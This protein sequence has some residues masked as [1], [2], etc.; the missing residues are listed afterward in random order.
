MNEGKQCLQ[1]DVTGSRCLE[2]GYGKIMLDVYCVPTSYGECIAMAK[3]GN[4]CQLLAFMLLLGKFST[5][6]CCAEVL[7]QPS[8]SRV[9]NTLSLELCH[10]TH[11]GN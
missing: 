2:E 4:E 3:T 7:F 11:H 8:F 1:R 10:G 5:V 6:V 9:E